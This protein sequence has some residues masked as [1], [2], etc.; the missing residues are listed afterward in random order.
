MAAAFQVTFYPW[1][2]CTLLYNCMTLL[3]WAHRTTVLQHVPGYGLASRQLA[4]GVKP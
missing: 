4:V 3:F 2:H 1:P